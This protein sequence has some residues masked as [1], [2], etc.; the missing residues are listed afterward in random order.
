MW[1]VCVLCSLP[2][3]VWFVPQF[4]PSP[5]TC[6][7][8]VVWSLTFDPGCLTPSPLTRNANGPARAIWGSLDTHSV[9]CWIAAGKERCSLG[10]GAAAYSSSAHNELAPSLAAFAGPFQRVYQGLRT[11]GPT[12]NACPQGLSHPNQNGL[13]RVLMMSDGGLV[14][15]SRKDTQDAAKAVQQQLE[16]TICYLGI[17]HLRQFSDFQSTCNQTH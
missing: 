17:M 8:F 15:E 14:C 9:D 4:F 2:G 13:R 1:R 11:S 10:T 6:P 16:R 5:S 3:P 7:D 12:Y